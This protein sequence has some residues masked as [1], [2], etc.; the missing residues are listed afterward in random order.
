M[1]GA[2]MDDAEPNPSLE[3]DRTADGSSR[4]DPARRIL[5]AAR[6]LF[7]SEGFAGVSTDRLAR[8]AGVSKSTLYKRFGDMAGL[9]RAVAEAEA[10]H[11]PLST[12]QVPATPEAFAARLTQMGAELIALIEQPDKVRFDRLVLEQAR[13]H[14]ELAKVYYEAIYARTQAQLAAF[15][16]EGQAGGVARSDL[17]PA[18]LADHLLCMWQGLAGVRSRL[19]L[20]DADP[21]PAAERSRQA[22]TTLLGR[23]EEP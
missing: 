22:V 17:P 12:A 16:R 19:G 4:E 18:V 20:P 21:C 13:A 15:L 7:F 9:L 23:S 1:L 14:P 6:E 5:R 8:A 2:D 11:V 3:A 10:D